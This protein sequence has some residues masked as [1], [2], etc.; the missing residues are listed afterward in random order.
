M[1]DQAERLTRE[2]G[3]RSSGRPLL[4]HAIMGTTVFVITEVMFFAALVSAFLVIKAG[5]V[6]GFTP[7]ENVT[8]PVATTALNSVILLMSGVALWMA[9]RQL[10]AEQGQKRSL[11]WLNQSWI[12]GAVFVGIQGR[13]WMDLIRFGMTL[14]SDVF[15]A[16]FYLLIGSHAIHAF[17][18]VI[19]MAWC[20][21]KWRRGTVSADSV[22]ALQIFWFFIVAVWPI[23]YGLIYF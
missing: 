9:G 4:P 11:F 6:G 3:G 15:G 12:L 23:L 13:E 7:P 2:I 19:V 17:C 22:T 20:S 5:T 16:C 10:S 18:A 14:K 8:L 21:W 1:V